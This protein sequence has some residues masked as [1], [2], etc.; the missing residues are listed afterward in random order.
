MY[1]FLIHSAVDD[2]TV[3]RLRSSFTLVTNALAAAGER[4]GRGSPAAG[5]AAATNTTSA[6]AAATTPVKLSLIISQ[7]TP[8]S[9][10]KQGRH[11][12]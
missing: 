11:Q 8:G 6:T 5:S 3:S 1:V 2:R 10:E 9:V 4:E 12:A 7:H